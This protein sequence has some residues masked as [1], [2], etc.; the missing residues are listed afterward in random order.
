MGSV[1]QAAAAAG[2]PRP[3]THLILS[4]LL[5]LPRQGDPLIAIHD[6]V[7]PLQ[8][9]RSSR[10]QLNREHAETAAGKGSR[11]QTQLRYIVP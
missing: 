6:C 2:H 10:T 11:P 1:L 7:R 3:T 8:A 9:A 4:V 5:R